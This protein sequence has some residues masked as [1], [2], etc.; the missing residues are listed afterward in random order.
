M[1]TTRLVEGLQAGA[2]EPIE[3]LEGSSL[4]AYLVIPRQWDS[5]QAEIK[6]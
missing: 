5:L 6:L 1:P 2:D 3:V 4:V